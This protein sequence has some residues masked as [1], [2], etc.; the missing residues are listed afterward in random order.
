MTATVGSYLAGDTG[1]GGRRTKQDDGQVAGRIV[2]DQ[3]H[4]LPIVDLA[5]LR[6]EAQRHHD[7]GWLPVEAA[8][9]ALR[10]MAPNDE[11]RVRLMEVGLKELVNTDIATRH[12]HAAK[13]IARVLSPAEA[14][15]YGPEGEVEDPLALRMVSRVTEQATRLMDW[16]H[17]DWSAWES[18][19]EGQTSAWFDRQ[20]GAHEIA[21]LLTK[22]RVVRTGDLPPAALE[23]VRAI[24]RGFRA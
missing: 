17:T 15:A 4:G 24:V 3:D 21:A 13:G 7:D 12:E 16:T 18:F 2:T 14:I 22:H 1:H 10:A 6:A 23:K 9:L 19:C 8:R 20:E 11:A 5:T